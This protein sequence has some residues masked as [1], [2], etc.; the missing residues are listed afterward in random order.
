MKDIQREKYRKLIDDVENLEAEI[1]K[2]EAR[3]GIFEDIESD[4][5]IAQDLQV[6]RS[7]LAEKRN[8]LARVSDGCGTPHAR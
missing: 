8:E 5:D 4:E 6:L 7:Q 3:E 1:E 2:Y